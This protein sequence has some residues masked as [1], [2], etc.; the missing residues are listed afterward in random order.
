MSQKNCVIIPG[1]ICNLGMQQ[2]SDGKWR[3][4]GLYKP[5]EN[6]FYASKNMQ[7]GPDNPRFKD[8][9]FIDKCREICQPNRDKHGGKNLCR[10]SFTRKSPK[11][12]KLECWHCNSAKTPKKWPKVNNL[13]LCKN[14]T[15]YSKNF[16]KMDN[17]SYRNT[18]L[19]Y[20]QFKEMAD[21]LPDY[22]LNNQESYFTKVAFMKNLSKQKDISE[23]LQY[24]IIDCKKKK[25]II[26][27]ELSALHLENN[28]LKKDYNKYKITQST[29]LK[30]LKKKLHQESINDIKNLEEE[31]GLYH[32]KFDKLATRYKISQEK[33]KL[34]LEQ[35]DNSNSKSNFN[36]DD[37]ETTNDD[38]MFDEN[39]NDIDFADYHDDT[40]LVSINDQHPFI[41]DTISFLPPPK[42]IKEKYTNT[43]N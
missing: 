28:E 37:F 19:N 15:A 21:N 41:D 12:G 10:G 43:F 36:F 23:K 16:S 9:I 22:Y 31:L 17:S 38:I 40:K 3:A 14:S 8:N 32:I 13:Q 39:D 25:D 34:C 27:D 18:E 26:R 24:E 30:I 2:G 4:K 11:N 6:H 5:N 35:L 1:A 33:Q 7:G 29:A 42:K 20:D